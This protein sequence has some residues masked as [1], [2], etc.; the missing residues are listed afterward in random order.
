MLGPCR[1]KVAGV[2]RAFVRTAIAVTLKWSVIADD[3]LVL[4]E[5]LLGQFFF[6][7]PTQVRDPK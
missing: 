7:L 5:L 3:M 1:L 6:T 4:M 2:I